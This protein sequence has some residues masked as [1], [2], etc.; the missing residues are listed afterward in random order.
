ME[1]DKRYVIWPKHHAEFMHQLPDD[2]LADVLPIA[3]KIAA[4]AKL[5]QYNVLQNNG[6]LANQAVP[7]VHFHI[8]PKPDR[9]QGLGIRWKPIETSMEKIQETFDEIKSNM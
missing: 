8:I 7:H 4:A 1:T 2:H 6:K 9:D 5:E 3:K